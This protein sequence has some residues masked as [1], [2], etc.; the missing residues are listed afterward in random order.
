MYANHMK[1]ANYS[2]VGSGNRGQ[3]VIVLTGVKLRQ[4]VGGRTC[5]PYKMLD[6]PM[7][8]CP[9]YINAK[10]HGI[11]GASYLSEAGFEQRD[12]VI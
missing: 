7:T 6:A 5:K 3:K 11:V 2:V 12:R 9:T 10:V 1:V 8:I 4:S